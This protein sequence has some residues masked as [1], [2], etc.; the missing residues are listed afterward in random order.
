MTWQAAAQSKAKELRLRAQ[1]GCAAALIDTWHQQLLWG[2]GDKSA[3]AL[4]GQDW[5]H[6]NI[7]Q[8]TNTAGSKQHSLDRLEAEAAHLRPCRSSSVASATAARQAA[9]TFEKSGATLKHISADRQGW[10]SS[11]CHTARC[12]VLCSRH[13]LERFDTATK[14]IPDRALAVHMAS[15]QEGVC[16]GHLPPV[17]GSQAEAHICTWAGVSAA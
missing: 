16:C 9:T 3:N 6:E 7:V 17:I 15:S 11:L 5:L 4:A 14:C 8:G 1:P 10:C 2:T 12:K 13:N